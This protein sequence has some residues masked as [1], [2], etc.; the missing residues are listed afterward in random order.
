[1]ATLNLIC[2]ILVIVLGF[3]SSMQ[4]PAALVAIVPRWQFY[5]P[6]ICGIAVNIALS[7]IQLTSKNK[8]HLRVLS[9]EITHWVVSLFFFRKIHSLKVGTNS[10][11]ITHSGGRF[12]DIFISLAPY[13]FPLFTIA[14]LVLRLVIAKNCLWGF[15][16]FVGLTLG[17]HIG[18]FASQI[19]PE[20]TD[21]SSHGV[22]KSY[23]FIIASWLFF[24]LLILYSIRYNLW[25]AFET[26]F[27]GYWKTLS[28]CWGMIA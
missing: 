16:V 19:S 2:Y 27:A 20:Q 23:I 17:F 1:M 21:I 22:V 13:C 11:Y 26:M 10:G 12:G 9:H 3:L 18:C 5:V 25:G 24:S 28:A 4:L 15:D 6:V 8:D 14:L 7:R